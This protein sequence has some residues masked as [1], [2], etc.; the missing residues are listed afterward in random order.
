LGE[1][2]IIIYFYGA[3]TFYYHRRKRKLTPQKEGKKTM[4]TI[5]STSSQPVAANKPSNF[6]VT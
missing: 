6:D 3:K 2:Y 5:D 1:N 4:H